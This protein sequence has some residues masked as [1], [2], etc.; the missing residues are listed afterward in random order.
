M[1][2]KLSI[3]NYALI[4][5]ISID[6]SNGF[7]VITGETGAG[8]SIILGAIQLLMGARSSQQLLKDTTKKAIVEGV[9]KTNKNLDK[10]LSALELD[11]EEELIIRREIKPNGSSRTFVN[12]SPVKIDK[13]KLLSQQI[14][15]LNGQHLI[16]EMGSLDFNY[17][18]IDAFLS[19][20]QP[21]EDY[22][23]AY[24]NYQ[25]YNRKYQNLLEKAS[26]L[27]EKKDFLNFQLKELSDYPIENWDEDAI[28]DEYN[29]VANQ[30]EIN[31]CL[32]TINDFYNGD[33]GISVQLMQLQ[34][35]FNSLVANLPEITEFSNR[36][37]A[38]SIEMNDLIEELN[39]KYTVQFPD[40]NRLNEL[41]D[42][43]S[44]IQFLVKK[45]NVV[46]L[47]SLITKRDVIE[48]EFAQIGNLESE[49]IDFKEKRSYWKDQCEEI[50]ELLMRNRVENFK[51]IEE[52][53][54]TVLSSISM[55]HADFKLELTKSVNIHSYGID[56]LKLLISV[57]NKSKYLPIHQFSSGGELSRIALAIKS[58]TTQSKS[59]PVL[60][61]DEIDTG[62]SGEVASKV[63]VLLKSIAKNMQVINIT[64]LPQVAAMGKVHFHVQKQ[65]N[66]N[67]IETTINALGREDRIQVLATMLGGNKTGNAA[68]NNALE[69]LN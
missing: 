69:L 22:N 27:N 1:L 52:S 32:S 4:N 26:L 38:V 45:F 49:L 9:F 39:K 16:N 59:I 44:Q 54:N 21:L 56:D 51:N 42:L 46:D 33:N 28:N 50:G 61:F 14:M 29:L 6:F 20:R 31:S 23:K 15:E 19:N 2:Q 68:R 60:I 67:G 48:E 34:V 17:R 24:L 47:N 8:K 5:N 7:T 55:A 11:L 37:N 13:L 12:D 35:S 36:V 62:I 65:D 3:Q 53:V 30:E 57:N 63:G 18:F 10:F 64:H 66:G 43:M 25:L 41:D 40:K 58:I